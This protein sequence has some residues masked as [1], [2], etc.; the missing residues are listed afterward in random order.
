MAIKVITGKP[1]SGKSYFALNKVILE[2]FSFDKKSFE[3][4]PK[5]DNITI[6]T[7]IEGLKIPHLELQSLIN[8][9]SNGDYERFFSCDIQQQITDKYPR[10]RYIIDECQRYF[11]NRF[12]NK[13][14]FFY[15]QYH[16]HYGHDIYLVAQVWDSISKHITGLCE[17]EFRA[18]PRSLSLLNDFN[19]GVYSGFDKVGSVRLPS[20]K[21]IFALYQSFQNKDFGK[22]IRPMRK[23]VVMA[24]G[25]LVC[26]FG[27]GYYWL[28]ALGDHSVVTE[29]EAATAAPP[30]AATPAAATPPA[31]PGASRPGR[32]PG[33]SVLSRSGKPSESPLMDPHQYVIAYTGSFMIGDKIEA[34]QWNGK[35]Y[36]AHAFPFQ[37]VHVGKGQIQVLLPADKI[38]AVAV[39]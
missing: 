35:M 34:I 26:A 12:Y 15:F 16:R 37:W 6:I 7:N 8:E 23:F 1:G 29:A 18:A 22:E 13:D 10:I 25:L 32:V 33:S 4:K 20:D 14:T 27:F 28:S 39:N 19:Y 38:Q 11:H 3:W 36:P 30:G 17:Y 24:L 5:K 21:K 9:Y 31:D 2:G